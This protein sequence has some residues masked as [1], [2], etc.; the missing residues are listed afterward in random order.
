MRN[1]QSTGYL[2]VIGEG[3]VERDTL[4]CNHCQRQV[5]ITPDKGCE[6]M[7]LG[8]CGACHRTICLKCAADL[9]RTLKCVTFEQRLDVLESRHRLLEAAGVEPRR[10]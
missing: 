2:Q 9:A 7:R 10:T 8:R 5:I 4:T 1:G 3:G 6:S